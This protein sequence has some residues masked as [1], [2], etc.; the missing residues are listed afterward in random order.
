MLG[1]ANMKRK[2]SIYVALFV[3]I[4]IV[5]PLGYY[6]YYQSTPGKL[7]SFA[8]C[9]GEK[10]AT[11]YGAFWCPHCQATKRMFGKSARL[12]PYVE[13]STPDG[14]NQTLICKQKGISSYPT[15]IFADGTTLMGEQTLKALSEKTG[16]PLPSDIGATTGVSTSASSA[17]TSS[18]Q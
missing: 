4:F 6:F 11:F 8:Q 12:L 16:C 5:A 7:D 2:S 13:C 15:W 10:K 17:A 3:L 18:A 1:L 9:L 14:N